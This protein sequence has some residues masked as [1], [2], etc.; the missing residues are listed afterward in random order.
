MYTSSTGEVQFDCVVPSGQG[1]KVGVR[2]EYLS[3]RSDPNHIKYKAPF[4]NEIV[5]S[6]T[7]IPT[8]GL[9]IVLLGRDFGDFGKA[10][11]LVA[12]V[13]VTTVQDSSTPHGR[14]TISVPPGIDDI[15][16]RIQVRVVDQTSPLNNNIAIQ[17]YAP[18]IV[19][20]VRP[21][22]RPSRG[23]WELE[24]LGFNFGTESYMV[25]KTNVTI[26]E[27]QCAVKSTS[28]DKIVCTMGAIN[29]R[30]SLPKVYVGNQASKLVS[31]RAKNV[32][33]SAYSAGQ[34]TDDQVSIYKA[35]KYKN[36]TMNARVDNAV[37]QQV[38]Y[39]THS[40]LNYIMMH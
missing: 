14:L 38:V 13:A 6:K 11:G 8:K 22:W 16:R 9:S 5:D 29:S 7:L 1:S 18:S 17:Y 33:L 30:G 10:V 2:V 27:T 35:L 39:I 32:A 12:S 28:Y 4:I 3:Y 26:G 40:T 25:S 23:G 20:I 34:A 31:V 19:D 37:N 36:D 24:I 15:P 21:L